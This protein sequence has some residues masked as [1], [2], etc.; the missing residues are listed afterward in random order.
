MAPCRVAY[1][2]VGKPAPL[3]NGRRQA[4]ASRSCCCWTMDSCW[5]L[6]EATVH[7]S[8][9]CSERRGAQHAYHAPLGEHHHHPHQSHR[10]HLVKNS[11]KLAQVTKSKVT[12]ARTTLN[13]Q[14]APDGDVAFEQNEGQGDFSSLC[15]FIIE[16]VTVSWKP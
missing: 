14:K 9:G 16:S 10:C 3:G 6:V 13:K 4:W 15:C 11:R 1:A 5:K 7:W 12:I 8:P 2:L